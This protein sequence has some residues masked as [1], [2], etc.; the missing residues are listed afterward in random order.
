M[1]QLPLLTP[2]V[3]PIFAQALLKPEG[4]GSKMCHL[5]L[6]HLVIKQPSTPC[7]S[8]PASENGKNNPLPIC[9]GWKSCFSPHIASK[10]GKAITKQG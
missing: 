3:V 5:F 10:N 7:L 9:K 2:C 8:F 6:F 1:S 4:E